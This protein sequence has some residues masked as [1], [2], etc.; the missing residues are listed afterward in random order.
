MPDLV[1]DTGSS[2]SPRWVAVR[3]AVPFARLGR[4]EVRLVNLRDPYIQE[5][6]RRQRLVPLPQDQQPS[7]DSKEEA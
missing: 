4:D 5:K 7:L 2:A 3:V 6:I 1:T